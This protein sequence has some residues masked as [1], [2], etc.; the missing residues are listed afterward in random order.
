MCMSP[1]LLGNYTIYRTWCIMICL[2]IPIL[3]LLLFI[4]SLSKLQLLVSCPFFCCYL[5][6]TLDIEHL[7]TY[8]YNGLLGLVSI[9]SKGLTKQLY[10]PGA[11]VIRVHRSTASAPVPIYIHVHLVTTDDIRTERVNKEILPGS[12]RISMQQ[13]HQ[14]QYYNVYSFVAMTCIIMYHSTVVLCI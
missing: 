14:L 4:Q 7:N 6:I 8:H 9:R 12:K 13:I 5:V 1:S 3:S 11:K 10:F 2:V